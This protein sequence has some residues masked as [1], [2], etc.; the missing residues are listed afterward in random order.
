MPGYSGVPVVTTLVC[1]LHIAHEA[2]GALGTRHSLRPLFA[3]RTI[4]AKPRAHRAARMRTCISNRHPR[5][6]ASPLSLE[7]RALRCTC[8]AG[9]ASKDERPGPSSFETH[10]FRD[11]PQ[12]DG[13]RLFEKLNRTL[14]RRPGQAKREPGPITTNV[15]VARSS[16]RSSVYNRHRWLWVPAFAGTT[17]RDYAFA[18][19]LAAMT[20]WLGCRP[21]HPNSAR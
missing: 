3:G 10:R 11:A 17:L 12:D 19:P 2:A 5:A 6:T 1:S 8:T 16:G 15:H 4:F 18:R 13:D 14:R 9:R 21:T 7:V 20:I